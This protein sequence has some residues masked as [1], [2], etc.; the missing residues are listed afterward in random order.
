MRWYLSVV[1]TIY[2]TSVSFSASLLLH[3]SSFSFLVTTSYLTTNRLSTVSLSPSLSLSLAAIDVASYGACSP[4]S[5]RNFH[6][7]T[8]PMG[9]GRPAANT[10]TPHIYHTLLCCLPTQFSFPVYYIYVKISAILPDFAWHA[11]AVPAGS[12]AWRWRHCMLAPSQ[13]C[14]S[15]SA[16]SIGNNQRLNSV[17]VTAPARTTQSVTTGII[18]NNGVRR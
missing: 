7:H 15:C 6:L 3:A 5:L 10:S 16:R 13:T 4:W 18:P 14:F 11:H 8:S 2:R 1:L 17:S 9:S 12:K